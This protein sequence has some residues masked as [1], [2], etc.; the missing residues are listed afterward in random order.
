MKV[1]GLTGGIA[2]GKS[3]VSKCL[4]N[5][6][7][8]V[9]L[10]ADE[11]ARE[12][13]EPGAPLWAAFVERYGASRVL[14]VNK[15]LNRQSIAEIVFSNKE[16]LSWMD[17]MAHPL[18]KQH[19]LKQLAACKA[20]GKKLVVLDVPLLFEAGWEKIPDEIWVVYVN[21]KTQLQRLMQRN[22]LSKASAL[23]RI[24]AQM[25]MDEKVRRADVVIDNNGT[26]EETAMQVRASLL[27]RNNH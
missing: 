24:A 18:I 16:E 3:T 21:P 4:R 9:I 23:E 15:N 1:I 7:G 22:T 17:D 2:S 27:Q 6:Y 26:I 19:L 11:I 12:I 20:E 5:D 8:A 13:A 10:D 14:D 25:P